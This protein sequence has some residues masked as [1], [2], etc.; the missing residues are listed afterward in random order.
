M[1]KLTLAAALFILSIH[2]LTIT[3]ELCKIPSIAGGT[4]TEFCTA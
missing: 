2:L 3:T 1:Q 4:R